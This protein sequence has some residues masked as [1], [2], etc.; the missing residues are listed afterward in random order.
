MVGYCL[1]GSIREHALFFLYGTGANGKTVFLSTITELLGEYAKTAPIAT[2]IAAGN[3]QHPTDLAGLCGARL[4]T[5]VETEDGR[6]WAE[7]K[8]K[9]LTGGDMIA[10]RFMRQDFFEFSP[11]FKLLIAGNHKPG[12]RSVDEAIR[13]RL[14]LIPF[15]VTIPA[16]ERDKHL[17]EKLR[18][19]WP[20]I[21][22]WAVEGCL[23]WQK[24]GL[25]PPA[26][27]LD[28]TATYLADEDRFAMWIEDRCNVGRQYSATA[29]E[30][31]RSWVLW[32]EGAGEKPGSQK[33]FSQTLEAHGFERGR[34]TTA[35][36]TFEGLAV[37]GAT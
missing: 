20:A 7:S 3:E 21:L 22:R 10:A 30:L 34:S 1:T 33:R 36:R 11:Q 12:L 28:A 5:A 9:V 37:E 25:D 35:A 14:H 26:T 6:R 13:R 17:K 24:K 15:S 18:A 4:V 2:F 31:Y 8:I 27:V 23:N 16:E 32:C 19:E 29:G